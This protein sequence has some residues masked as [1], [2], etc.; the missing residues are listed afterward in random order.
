M[1]NVNR[2]RWGD[3][4]IICVP[5][6]STTIIEIGDFVC[7]VIQVD[8]DADSTLTINYGCPA[9]DLV[10]GAAAATDREKG[11]DQFLGIAMSA[12]RDGDTDLLIVGTAGVWE[13]QQKTAAAIHIG[14]NVGIYSDGTNCED[15]TVVEDDTSYIGKC[16]ENKSS[17]SLT[18]VMVKLMPS[19]LNTLQG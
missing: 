6:D 5:V 12:T 16:V 3:Q 14:D 8:V 1:A 11:A 18:G 4:E 9:S 10:T 15:K 19:L 2:Y 7:R 13:L 17:T